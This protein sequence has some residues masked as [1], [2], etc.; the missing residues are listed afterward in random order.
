MSLSAEFTARRESESRLTRPTKQRDSSAFYKVPNLLPQLGKLKMKIPAISFSFLEICG[1]IKIMSKELLE[2][3]SQKLILLGNEAIVRGALEAGVQ[4]VAT[5]PGTPASEIGNNFAEIAKNNDRLYFEFSTNEKLAMEAVIGASFTGLRCLVAMKNFGLNVASDSLLPFLYT[6]SVGPTVIVVADDPSCHSSAQSEEN[7]RGFAQL[8]HI[9]VLEPSDSQECLD[10]T[11][12]AFEISEKFK[13]PVIVRLTTRVA[14]QR[15]VV[16]ISNL[17]SQISNIKGAEFI[18]D[19]HRFVTMPPRVLEMHQELLDKVAKIKDFAEQSYINKSQIPI[20]NNQTNPKSQIPKIGVITSGV[21]YLHTMEA[22]EMLGLDIPVLKLGFFYPLAEEKIKDFIKPLK[23]VLVVEELDPYLEKEIERL[24][25]VAN[26]KIKIFGKDLLSEVGEMKP[27]YVVSALKQILGK[28]IKPAAIEDFKTIKHKPRFCTTPMCPYWRVFAA[29]KKATP[30]GTIFGGDI[31][32]YMIA[33]FEPMQVYDY[34][35]CMGSSIGI[36]HGVAKAVDGKQ[37]V[38]TLMGD[39]TFFHAGMP[40]LLNAVYNQSNILA[41]IVDNRITAMTGHQP[42]PG[43]G[44]NVEGGTV[45]EI[46]IEEVVRSLGVKAENLRV[47][48]PVDNFD[49]L[50]SAVQE[51]YPRNEVSVIIARRMCAL[52]EKRQKRS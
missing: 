28:K 36:G 9:P 47:V 24:A 46:K 5:Y 25:K 21:S 31:G 17:K 45:P 50:V 27:E 12:L 18:R 39:G 11:K 20:T 26:P 4:F 38:I 16:A 10:F 35:F 32:C 1:K 3:K 48:D 43:M 30:Q 6:G 8:A 7:S 29:L 34:M 14:H 19:K 15:S 33:G 2:E 37:K 22:M 23:K 13:L 41:I 40:A 42:N 52:L 49:S 44:E 51:F